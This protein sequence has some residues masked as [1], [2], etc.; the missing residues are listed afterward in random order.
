MGAGVG[1]DGDSR[2]YEGV[3]MK[4]KPTEHIVTAYA[5]P[6]DGPGWSNRPLWVIVCDRTD[7]S[8]RRECIQ[9]EKQTDEMRVLYATAAAVHTALVKS[10]ERA[11]VR[12]KARRAG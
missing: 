7:G 2:G 10:V 6:A 1:G 11:A 12:P 9:P 8:L 4:I 3:S 5:Q